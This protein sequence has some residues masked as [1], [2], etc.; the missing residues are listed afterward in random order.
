MSLGGRG[1]KSLTLREISSGG[2][3]LRANA[4]DIQ[5]GRFSPAFT[6][7]TLLADNTAVSTTENIIMEGETVAGNVP[8][9]VASLRT[10]SVASDSAQDGVAGTGI[11][12]VIIFGLD[13]NSNQIAEFLTMNGT[14]PVDSALQYTRLTDIFGTSAGTNNSNVGTIYVSDDTDTFTSGIPQNRIYSL[15]DVGHSFNKVGLFSLG[16][17]ASTKVLIKRIIINTD[18]TESKPVTVRLYRTFRELDTV[19]GNMEILVGIFYLANLFVGDFSVDRFLQGNDEL[20]VT[21]QTNTGSVK[22]NVKLMLLIAAPSN[23]ASGT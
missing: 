4:E 21:A 15:I 3:F 8:T 12:T 11:L 5:F 9:R 7:S 19:G 10:I 1:V 23:L 22:I 13:A 14:T 6:R 16:L 20:R 18:A 2:G 17:P